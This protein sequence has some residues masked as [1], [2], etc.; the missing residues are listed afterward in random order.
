MNKEELIRRIENNDDFTTEK[1]WDGFW[2]RRKNKGGRTGLGVGG[3]DPD[4]ASYALAQTH[5]F[6]WSGRTGNPKDPDCRLNLTIQED[7]N[8]YFLTD[9]ISGLDLSSDTLV[10]GYRWERPAVLEGVIL[11]LIREYGKAEYRAMQEAFVRTAYTVG[12]LTVFPRRSENN[13]KESINCVRG[14]DYCLADR[15]DLTMEWIRR[16][17]FGEKTDLSER[18]KG[19]LENNAGFFALFGEGRGGFKAF[20]DF[21]FLNDLVSTDYASVPVF[22]GDNGFTRGGFPQ[23]PRE[24]LTWR[25]KATAF[26]KARNDRILRA[27]KDGTIDRR[28][29]ENFCCQQKQL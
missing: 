25:D 2:E 15:I 12:G 6:L 29:T 26:V 19:V 9:E 5:A 7:N 16:Y 27:L 4:A 14:K 10:N 22:F 17:Y 20:V 24:W 13:D 11:P 8:G 18:T 21:F 28:K 1:Y 3:E 23:T